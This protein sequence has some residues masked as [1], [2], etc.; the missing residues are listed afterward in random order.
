MFSSNE[1]ESFYVNAKLGQW[2]YTDLL[3]VAKRCEDWV[4]SFEAVKTWHSDAETYENP[5]ALDIAADRSLFAIAMALCIPSEKTGELFRKYQPHLW[6]NGFA[7]GKWVNTIAEAMERGLP[8]HEIDILS[9]FALCKPDHASTVRECYNVEMPDVLLYAARADNLNAFLKMLPEDP[10]DARDK[11]FPVLGQANLQVDTDLYRH[12]ITSPIDERDLFRAKVGSIRHCAVT[13]NGFNGRRTVGK[14]AK[15]SSIFPGPNP[16][17]IFKHPDFAEKVRLDVDHLVRDFFYRTDF[18]F[19][20]PEHN[21]LAQAITKSF[22]DAG[23]PPSSII[24]WC[25]FKKPSTEPLVTL[26]LALGEYA[27]MH[28]IEQ[29]FYAE[30]YRQYLKDF[31]AEKIIDSCFRNETLVAAYR[32]TGDK[33]IIKSA[34][35]AVRDACFGNDLGL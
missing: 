1:I 9:V 4:M 7:I 14:G 25:V 28:P 3:A 15:F 8:G 10:A 27:A 31:T 21:R 18:R 5:H 2:A 22:V 26:S 16:T 23:V 13:D 35:H 33:A 29:E 19:R 11:A 20:Y 30:V 6:E 24:S 17:P 12:F 34:N 32:L